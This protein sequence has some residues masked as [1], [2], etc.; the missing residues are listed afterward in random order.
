MHE[1]GLILHENTVVTDY[2]HSYNSQSNSTHLHVSHPH[3]II[4]YYKYMYLRL[5]RTDVIDGRRA[6]LHDAVEGRHQADL[7]HLLLRRQTC[8]RT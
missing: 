3:D 8:R 1:G 4:I 6:L 7:D 2:I 5:A